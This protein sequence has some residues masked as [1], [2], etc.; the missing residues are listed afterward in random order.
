MVRKS[1]NQ[2]HQKAHLE[3]CVIYFVLGPTKKPVVMLLIFIGFEV[4]FIGRFPGS[5]GI[6][7]I[8]SARQG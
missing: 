7:E 8:N 3:I 4:L 1:D 2:S 6:A 5:F